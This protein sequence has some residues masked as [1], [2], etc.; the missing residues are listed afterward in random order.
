MTK[1]TNIS[2]ATYVMQLGNS[3]NTDQ[4]QQQQQQ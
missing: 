3:H 2:L 4:Q 1:I